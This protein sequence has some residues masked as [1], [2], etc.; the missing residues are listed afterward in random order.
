ML[1]QQKPNVEKSLK[2][3]VNDDLKKICK[4]YGTAV[5]GTKP[6]LQK[7]CIDGEYQPFQHRAWERSG[8]AAWGSAR[9]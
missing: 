3:L 9:D 5:S 8:S 7:R 4:A 1:I 6:V 2:L